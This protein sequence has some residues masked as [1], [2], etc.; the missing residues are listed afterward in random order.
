MTPR[1]REPLAPKTTLGIGGP[2]SVFIFAESDADVVAAADYARE[3]RMQLRV[4]GAGSNLLVPDE[5]IEAVVVRVTNKT[6]SFDTARDGLV[7]VTAG[8]G[9]AWD[10][11][12]DAAAE[13][14]L[15]GIENLA[16][17]P[18]TVGGAAVQNIGAY[19]AVL[20]DVFTHA[21]VY[22][23]LTCATERIE[24]TQAAFG[25][26][27]SIFKSRRECIILRVTLSLASSGVLKLE[28][29]DLVRFQAERGQL[30]TPAQT[31]R[32]IRAI[33]AK[34]FPDLSREGTAGSFFANPVLSESDAQ[35]LAARFPGLP[36]FSLPESPGRMKVPLAWILEHVLHLK[37]FTL[38]AAR[39]YEKH[40]LVLVVSRDGNARTVDALAEEVAQRVHAATGIV[41]EREVETFTA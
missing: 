22:N 24:R 21:E 11:L 4:I 33:R 37:G 2:A 14:G 41:V 25:Y 30:E 31:A 3:H 23:T 32:T 36:L 15:Y 40:A 5:G 26:R 19:G 34:K 6:I 12:V 18:G 20:S 13:R 16:G 38:G 35:A 27:A 7:L 29:P 39:L 28:Y 9:A 17:V 1:F 10:A 8:A